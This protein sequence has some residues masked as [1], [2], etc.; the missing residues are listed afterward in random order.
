[1]WFAHIKTVSFSIAFFMELAMFLPASLSIKFN[2][3][4][5]FMLRNLF[6]VRVPEFYF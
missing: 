6:G 2:S 5:G 4:R 1:M 3:S